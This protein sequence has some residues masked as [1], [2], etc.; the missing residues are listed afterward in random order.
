MLNQPY[1]QDLIGEQEGSGGMDA[2]P[3]LRLWVI[4]CC[5]AIGVLINVAR[6]G[7]IQLMI[8]EHFDYAMDV[9][10]ERIEQIPRHTGRILSREGVVLAADRDVYHLAV[11][12]R[13]LEEPVDPQWLREQVRK[14]LPVSARKNKLAYQQVE[15]NILKQR[16]DLWK[17]VSAITALTPERLD[18]SRKKIQLQVEHIAQSVRARVTQ[19]VEKKLAPQNMQEWWSHLQ[20]ELTTPPKRE[21]Q[22]RDLVIQEELA[23]HR[24]VENIT[25]DQ[26]LYI[27]AHHELLPGTSIQRAQERIYQQ[28]DLAAHL[29]GYRKTNQG[30]AQHLDTNEEDYL[31]GETIGLAGVERQAQKLLTGERGEKKLV[32]SQR[33][34]ILSE[35]ITKPLLPGEDV[36]LSISARLQQACERILD[37]K[38]LP[39]ERFKPLNQASEIKTG[40]SPNSGCILMMDVRSGELLATAVAPRPHIGLLA[41]G[42]GEYWQ[43]LMDDPRKPLFPRWSHLELPPGSVFKIASSVALLEEGVITG[44][45]TFSCQGFL[46]RPDRHRCYVFRHFGVGHG[47]ITFKEAISRSCNVFFFEQARKAG[48]ELLLA[49]YDRLGF[50]HVTSA[51][52]PGERQGH[53]PDPTD[54]KHFFA[55]DTLGMAIG[56]STVLVTPL[57]ILKLMGIIASGGKLIEPTPYLNGSPKERPTGSIEL[58]HHETAIKD[59]VQIVSSRTSQEIALAMI[60]TIENPRGTGHKAVYMPEVLIAGKTGTA[61]TGRETDHAWFAGF[62]PADKPRIAFVVVLEDGGSGGADAGPIAKACVQEL[63]KQ[64]FVTPRK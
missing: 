47:E 29:I 43:L 7:Y 3:Q 30:A 63:L 9:P 5:V 2:R 4:W 50:G 35:E 25:L 46:D 53:L 15:Q 22:S 27:E 56:Q 49:W 28:G 1:H 52:T 32:V 10:I 34:E 60:D 20:Q 42:D 59:D 51:T 12:Y 19:Q 40:G 36:T 33:G 24:V 64:G 8:P 13:W 62:V 58:V 37:K 57:Q 14:K 44:D 41:R 48:P 23:Y 54:K 26:V 31:P 55:G 38:I 6:I 21:T 61:E 39:A 17:Q 16:S 11:H 45:Q 18:E